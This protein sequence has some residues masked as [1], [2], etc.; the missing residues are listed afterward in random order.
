MV[1]SVPE[2]TSNVKELSEV[3]LIMERAKELR[4]NPLKSALGVLKRLARKMEEYGFDYGNAL[5]A[6]SE[7]FYALDLA[8]PEFLCPWCEVRGGTS[9]NCYC[10]GRG[11]YNKSQ[12]A[13]YGLAKN[14]AALIKAGHTGGY[15]STLIKIAKAGGRDAS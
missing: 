1:S 6:C 2:K 7:G 14:R 10:R 5:S 13:Q 12:M 4:Q 11:W 8:L 9:N 3:L 15:A